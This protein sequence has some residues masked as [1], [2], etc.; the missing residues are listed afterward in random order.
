VANSSKPKRVIAGRLSASGAAAARYGTVTLSVVR[1]ILK[2]RGGNMDFRHFRVYVDD[3]EVKGF[4]ADTAF[5]V[6]AIR[7]GQG[8]ATELLVP[9]IKKKL[10]W[11]QMKHTTF[12][13]LSR[14]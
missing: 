11:V 8:G 6:L 14:V 5:P 1:E 4:D 7:D 3:V 13:G 12:M 9:N 2:P 10:T